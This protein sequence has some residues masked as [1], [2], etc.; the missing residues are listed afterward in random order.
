MIYQSLLDIVESE[1]H[2]NINDINYMSGLLKKG[3]KT[4][5]Q[6][7]VSGTIINTVEANQ[8]RPEP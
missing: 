5:H 8:S 4:K 2:L 3:D 7:I 6:D 1:N